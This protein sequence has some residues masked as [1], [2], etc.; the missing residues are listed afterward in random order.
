MANEDL[1]VIIKA[2]QLA[3]HTLIVTSKKR[4]KRGDEKCSCE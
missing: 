3:K 4:M 1:Q 2:K